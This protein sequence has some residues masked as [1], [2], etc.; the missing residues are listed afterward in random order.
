[1]S[2]CGSNGIIQLCCFEL[3]TADGLFFFVAAPR[4]TLAG[5]QSTVTALPFDD[6]ETEV[7]DSLLSLPTHTHTW[8]VANKDQL[9][10]VRQLLKYSNCWDAQIGLL[11]DGL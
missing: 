8:A 7:L 5:L 4:T 11:G 9:S 10:N 3:P 6:F 2:P 1:M